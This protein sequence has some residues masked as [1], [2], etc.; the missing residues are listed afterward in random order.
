MKS[1][2]EHYYEWLTIPCY[3]WESKIMPNAKPFGERLLS[4]DW[5]QTSWK[6]KTSRWQTFTTNEWT[7]C[8]ENKII[9][10]ENVCSIFRSILWSRSDRDCVSEQRCWI[11]VMQS[12]QV[13]VFTQQRLFKALIQI[14]FPDTFNL[15]FDPVNHISN[16]LLDIQFDIF[17]VII[18]NNNFIWIWSSR[19]EFFRWINFGE[20]IP[21]LWQGSCETKNY[22]LRNIS[23][24]IIDWFVVIQFEVW[25]TRQMQSWNG[26]LVSVFTFLARWHIEVHWPKHSWK[27]WWR[28]INDCSFI[29]FLPAIVFEQFSNIFV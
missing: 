21:S 18:S 3:E 10:Y 20:K 1:P 13:L 27:L 4:C 16:L 25:S 14:I 15:I 28:F 17:I 12:C 22:R 23:T 29:G 19:Q 6:S 2:A 5:K 8:V 26:S 7:V 11:K 9:L 24:H